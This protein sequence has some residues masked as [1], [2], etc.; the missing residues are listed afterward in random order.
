ME[1]DIPTIL[2]LVVAA[3]AALYA[4]FLKGKTTTTTPATTAPT[5]TAPAA[6]PTA[7]VTAPVT[8]AAPAAPAASTV[9][10]ATA[11]PAI[12]SQ[13]TPDTF[14]AAQHGGKGPNNFTWEQMRQWVR[15]KVSDAT[16][17]DMLA[18]LESPKD[19]QDVTDAIAAAEKTNEYLYT[20]DFDH[21][22]YMM[23]AVCSP[24]PGA[25]TQYKYQVVVASSGLDKI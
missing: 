24:V 8:P 19:I 13:P 25:P 3:G 22:Y 2:A 4:A 10:T 6:T 16:R 5:A 15:F 21:G 1:F 17:R 12:I 7:A 9:A 14:D 11:A 18:P 23:K 20:I